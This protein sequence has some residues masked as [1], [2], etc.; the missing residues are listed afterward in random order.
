VVVTPHPAEMGRL[1]G[2]A[3]AAVQQA[4]EQVARDYATAQGVVVILKGSRTV[5][6]APD[7][8]L[9][10]DDHEVVALASGGTGDVLA[11][12]C[13]AML[14]A[15]LPAFEAAVAAVTI[16]VEA[17]VDVQ[18]HRGRAGALAGDVLEAL[19]AA[20]ERLR[21]VLEAQAASPGPLT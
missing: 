19:P 20:Q 11:G 21:R 4:R 3:T 16:H 2:L 8:R 15:G 1:A 12:L 10:V 14:A 7:G 5:V 17:G 9:H 6:A 13:G 18:A